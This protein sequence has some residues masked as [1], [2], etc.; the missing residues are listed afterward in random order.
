MPCSNLKLF[1]FAVLLAGLS[2]T[3]PVQG[4]GQSQQSFVAQ[5]TSQATSQATP[6]RRAALRLG[7]SQRARESVTAGSPSG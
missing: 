2:W 3:Q 1:L 5:P 6:H 7:I 4:Q